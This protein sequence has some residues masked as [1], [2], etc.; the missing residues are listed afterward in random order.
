MNDRVFDAM[1]SDRSQAMQEKLLAFMEEHIYPSETAITLA[2]HAMGDA[3]TPLPQIE[4]LKGIARSRGLWNLFLPDHAQGAGL[5][6]LEYAPLAEVMGRVPFASEVFNCSAP[7]TGNMEL[8]A[9]YGSSAQKDRW[10]APLLEGKTRSAFAMTEPGVASSDATNLQATITASEDGS[11]YYLNGRKW[12]ITNAMSPVCDF[13]IF[14]GRSAHS[15]EKHKNHSMVI[16]DAEAP[17]IDVL[18]P[19]RVFGFEDRPYG[20]AE[21][22][23]K[24][25]FVPAE[26][27]ILG[28]G[29]GFEIAQGRLGPGRIHHCMR[30]IGLAERLLEKMSERALRR[31]AFGKALADRDT[32]RSDIAFSKL[33]IEQAR[34]LTLKAAHLLDVSGAKAARAEIAGIKVVAPRMAQRVADRALQVFGAAGLCDD[35][36]IAEAYALARYLRIADGPDAVH[37]ETVAKSLLGRADRKSEI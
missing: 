6:N 16:V 21:I 27:M 3:W 30:L 18:R 15:N 17:G 25:V 4:S 28:E 32:V 36:G 29:R 19:L 22:D 31:R 9:K 23:F 1:A 35:F 7:D 5:T 24:N 14:M 10:L 13:Y 8:L 12:W 26:N 11:G 2:M 34:L 20:H 33:E 37:I